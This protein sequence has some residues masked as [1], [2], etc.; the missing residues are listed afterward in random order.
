VFGEGN[1]PGAIEFSLILAHCLAGCVLSLTFILISKHERRAWPLTW[2]PVWLTLPP[3]AIG[4]TSLFAGRTP[5]LPSFWMAWI[6]A[7]S[8]ALWL[9]TNPLP[10]PHQ[11][12]RI[13]LAAAI[14][15]ILG[16]ILPLS[17]LPGLNTAAV[18]LPLGIAAS[19]LWRTREVRGPGRRVAAIALTAFGLEILALAMLS[20]GGR[21]P[22]ADTFVATVILLA[23]MTELVAALGLMLSHI[24]YAHW[25]SDKSRG[26]LADATVDPLTEFHNRR[27]FRDFVDRVRGGETA[28]VGVILVLDLDG[29]KKINDQKGHS[30]GDKAILRTSQAIRA[31]T[32]PGDLL[33][34]WGGDEFVIVLPGCDARS[35]D[36]VV[37][38]IQRGLA[39]ERLAASIGL[40]AY[41]PQ[42]DAVLALR[43]ADQHMYHAKRR[44]QARKRSESR[45]LS[46]PLDAFL[47]QHAE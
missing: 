32:R 22:H 47:T 29:L 16:A 24:A 28:P 19:R 17:A 46:L 42:H 2:A 30:A 15:A 25:K 41:G 38:K 13:C 9:T 23:L 35:G 18:T 26:Q 31:A 12:F 8:I 14:G 27:L 1:T 34:R 44:R 40:S 21:W 33:I 39:L 11:A 36:D 5:T 20:L 10:W 3:A 7:H 45:Q 6:A 4:M 37:E 43:N